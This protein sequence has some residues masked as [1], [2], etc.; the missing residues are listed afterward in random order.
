MYNKFNLFIVIQNLI[1]FNIIYYHE[2]EKNEKPS[3]SKKLQK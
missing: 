2:F 1:Y 3:Y